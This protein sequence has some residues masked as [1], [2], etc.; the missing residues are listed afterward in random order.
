MKT[1]VSLDEGDLDRCIEEVARSGD[2]THIIMGLGRGRLLL[3]QS[4]MEFSEDLLRQIARIAGRATHVHYKGGEY[5]LLADVRLEAEPGT[6]HVLYRNVKTGQL[7]VRP[8]SEFHGEVEVPAAPS[9]KMV[10]RFQQIAGWTHTSA[11]VANAEERAQFLS[12]E[13]AGPRLATVQLTEEEARTVMALSTV[14][15]V[16]ASVKEKLLRATTEVQS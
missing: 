11:P 4:L 9:R 15:P 10:P 12:G 16:M 6:P 13:A 3:A 1:T 7:W 14:T 5:T 2:G 8:K